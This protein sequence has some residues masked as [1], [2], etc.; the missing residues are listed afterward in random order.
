MSADIEIIWL[1]EEQV[2]QIH[3]YVLELDNVGLAGKAPEK[4][5]SG[6]LTRVQNR[7]HYEGE[8]DLLYLAAC[9]GMAIAMGH[10]YNDANKRTAFTSMDVFLRFNGYMMDMDEDTIISLM[11][12]TAN[13]EFTHEELA[14]RLYS[15][16]SK[17]DT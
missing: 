1:S 11:V 2:D 4:S 7:Y 10:I 12:S 17:F 16:L 8:D 15:N 3:D 9:Y 5:I 6:T 14:D 13:G